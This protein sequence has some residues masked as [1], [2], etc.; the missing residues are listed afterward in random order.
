MKG[1]LILSLLIYLLFC[2]E[3]AAKTGSLQLLNYNHTDLQSGEIHSL[4]NLKGKPTLMMFFEP[5]CPWCFKQG[6]AFNKLLEQCPNAINIVALGSGD[7]ASLKKELWKMRLLFPGYQVGQTMLNDIGQIPAT[8]I[9][10]ITDRQGNYK[11]Y[12][13]G[14]IKLEQLLPMLKKNLG[15]KCS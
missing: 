15:L 1:K 11:S 10:L 9:T 4:E 3:L 12:L 13:R 6:K 7:K 5:Q 2:F 14:Y 8:P